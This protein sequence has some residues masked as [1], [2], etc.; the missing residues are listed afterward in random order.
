MITLRSID[1]MLAR[2]LHRPT[3]ANDRPLVCRG[4]LPGPI[5][6]ILRIRD[7]GLPWPVEP[8]QIT[9]ERIGTL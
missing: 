9:K 6:R 7:A 2:M 5:D 4:Y 8:Q 1:R 3:V